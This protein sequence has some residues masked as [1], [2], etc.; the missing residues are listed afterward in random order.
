MRNN[1]PAVNFLPES[2][3]DSVKAAVWTDGAGRW[4]HLPAAAATTW[5]WEE[6]NDERANLIPLC[7]LDWGFFFLLCQSSGR[8]G[9][10]ISIDYRVVPVA[11]ARRRHRGGPGK[12]TLITAQ[13]DVIKCWVNVSKVSTSP[14]PL[15][16]HH[17]RLKVNFGPS[18]V[19]SGRP[20]WFRSVKST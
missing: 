6:G 1:Q 10:E 19:K 2:M 4:C 13:F 12:R 17:R 5:C 11:A 16:R 15:W 7:L 18:Q 3:A 14:P 8:F 20:G 9:E